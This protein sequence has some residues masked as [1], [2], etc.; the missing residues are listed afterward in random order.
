L[1]TFVREGISGATS[2]LHRR[3]AWSRR[4]A[5][6]TML[7]C[8]SVRSMGARLGLGVSSV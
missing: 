1:R 7:G 5:L 8:V 6:S 3:L 4:T 2:Y